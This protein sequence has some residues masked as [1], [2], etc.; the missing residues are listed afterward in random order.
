MTTKAN[1]ATWV[2]YAAVRGGIVRCIHGNMLVLGKNC[3]IECHSIPNKAK[4]ATQFIRS[5]MKSFDRSEFF[6]SPSILPR[7]LQASQIQNSSF[8]IP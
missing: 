1:Q 8:H 5:F 7:S 3:I 6:F 4:A 2:P